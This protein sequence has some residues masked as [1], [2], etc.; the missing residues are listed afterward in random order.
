MK[1]ARSA[2][3]GLLSIAV[4]CAAAQTAPPKFPDAQASD[5]VALGWMMGFPPPPD[6]VIR[7]TDGSSYRFP[8]LRW[9]FSNSACTW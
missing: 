4:S 7:S 6:R 5:P 2:L 8:Q 3:P 1:L 9:A